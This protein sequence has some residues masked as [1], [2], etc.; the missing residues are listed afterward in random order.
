MS[1]L[2]LSAVRAW[3]AHAL[4]LGRVA[5]SRSVLFALLAIVNADLVAQR[6]AELVGT[7]PAASAYANVYTLEGRVVGYAVA[8]LGGAVRF[9]DLELQPTGTA[10]LGSYDEVR[11]IRA[12]RLPTNL[13]TDRESGWVLLE[14]GFVDGEDSGRRASIIAPAGDLVAD[15]GTARVTAFEW[16]DQAYLQIESTDASREL[17]LIGRDLK[18]LYRTP[19][20]REDLRL[21][22]IRLGE[23]ARFNVWAKD[24]IRILDLQ[25]REVAAYAA[26]VDDS[27]LWRHGSMYAYGLL[28]VDVLAD[29][30]PDFGVAV[31]DDSE[32]EGTNYLAVVDALG[33]VL[34]DSLLPAGNDRTLEYW[35]EGC[36]LVLKE[37]LPPDSV[38]R[39]YTYTRS[40]RDPRDLR[41]L[42]ELFPGESFRV[43]SYDGRTSFRYSLEDSIVQFD[44]Y[45]AERQIGMPRAIAREGTR[46]TWHGMLD[47]KA[48]SAV[49]GEAIYVGEQPTAEGLYRHV[50]LTAAQQPVL[51]FK[52][53][54]Y[55]SVFRGVDDGVYAR[56]T[57]S[58]GADLAEGSRVY[59][60]ERSAGASSIAAAPLHSPGPLFAPNPASAAIRLLDQ[61]GLDRARVRVYTAQGALAGEWSG[62]DPGSRLAFDLPPGMYLVEV[63]ST[64]GWQ[65]T[66]SLV[67][68]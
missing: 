52:G 5:L 31:Y 14:I 12:T 64:G 59:R 37:I 27:A 7:L 21:D 50:T 44:P 48:A 47:F 51:A 26:S 36:L 56:S 6:Q 53:G 15:Y 18:T 1:I 57:I 17:S 23:Q 49:Y 65:R 55:A 9:F 10:A 11:W 68:R 28:P 30:V 13:A 67:V 4:A 3:V 16:G 58:D 22:R 42:P 41:R 2:T 61:P 33:N 34:A 46:Y 20:G 54:R 60:L 35:I 39:R 66:S 43:G 40:A 32:D 19:P 25:G 63:V 29:G 38:G 45:S 24:S 62:A 8:D